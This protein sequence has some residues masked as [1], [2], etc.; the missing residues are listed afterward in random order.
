[1]SF[2]PP[3]SESLQL[4]IVQQTCKNEHPL[5]QTPFSNGLGTPSRRLKLNSTAA[6][7]VISA[8]DYTKIIDEM[9][10]ERRIRIYEALYRLHHSD[11]TEHVANPQKDPILWPQM[12][13]EFQLMRETEDSDEKFEEFCKSGL[14]LGVQIAIC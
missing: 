7:P 5:T 11:V 1:M 6:A 12:P 13:K 9:P 14:F 4:P 8:P 3:K 10:E 2:P